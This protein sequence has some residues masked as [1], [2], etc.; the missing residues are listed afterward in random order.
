MEVQKP[1]YPL[2]FESVLKDYIWGGRN[3]EKLGKVLPPEGKVAESWEA[4]CHPNGLSVVADG[5]L[6]GKTL[7]QVIEE[8]G[9]KIVGTRFAGKKY[10]LL[11]KFIDANDRLSFQVHPDDDYAGKFE[12]GGLGKNEMWYVVAAEPGAFLYLGLK[13]GITKEQFANAIKEDRV[14]ECMSKLEVQAGDAVNIPAGTIHA[15]CEGL[16]IIEVQQSSDLTYRVYDYS[17]IDSSGNTRP[18]HINKALD[19]ISFGG[20]Q[21]TKQKGIKVCFDGEGSKIVLAANKYFAAEKWDVDG[22]ISQEANGTNFYL[23]TLIDGFLDV[24]YDGG[25]ISVRKGQTVFIPAALGYY[26][27]EGK[28]QII[29]SYVPDLEKDIYLPLIEKGFT[30]EQIDEAI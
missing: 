22:M 9:D 18:L 17:R 30:R 21:S 11:V 29:K 19:V 1:I 13:Q 7:F 25:S 8:Y 4:S 15:I 10:P 16:L 14:E 5:F 27:I 24:G 23:Y 3:L 6:K 28:A 2:T 20:Q 26:T 12:N